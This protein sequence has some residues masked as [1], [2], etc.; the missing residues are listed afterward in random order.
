MSDSPL[1]FVV[2]YPKGDRFWKLWVSNYVNG[3]TAFLTKVDRYGGFSGAIYITTE[4]ADDKPRRTCNI[5]AFPSDAF[6]MEVGRKIK[7]DLEKEPGTEV[8]YFDLSRFR[9]GREAE[10]YLREFALD[11]RITAAGVEWKP[12]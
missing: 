12:Q 6:V 10:N 4:S 11:L 9:T 2:N 3:Q 8:S 5:M 1:E 7:E